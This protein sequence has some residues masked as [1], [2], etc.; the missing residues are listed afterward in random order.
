MLDSAGRVAVGFA[1]P[2]KNVSP[3]WCRSMPSDSARRNSTVRMR[4]PISLSKRQKVRNL[5]R[6]PRTSLTI[7]DLANPYVSVEIRGRAELVP[8]PTKRLSQLLSHKYLGQDPP[9]E[10]GVSRVVVRVVPDKIV[11]FAA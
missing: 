2:R 7:F 3:T 5:D 1:V 10:P 4:S 11:H 8:A 6:D 9:A